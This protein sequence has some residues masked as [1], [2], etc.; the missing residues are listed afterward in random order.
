MPFKDLQESFEAFG[1][2]FAEAGNTEADYAE[3]G[4]AEAGNTEAGNAEADNT[5][6]GNTEAGN[7]EALKHL[8]E[9]SKVHAIEGFA[10]ESLWFCV[11]EIESKLL[12]GPQ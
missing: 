4:N 9:R 12:L 10:V 11:W 3:A 5:E 7:A 1:N 2:W 6:A 8:Q